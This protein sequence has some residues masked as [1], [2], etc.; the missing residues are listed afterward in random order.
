[1]AILVTGGAGYIGSHMVYELADAAERVVVLDNL[2]TGFDWAVAKGVPVIVGDTGDQTLV[3]QIIREHNIDSIV[4]FAACLVVPDSV[5]DPLGY[6]KNNTVLPG[7]D[8][9]CQQ[10]W[11]PSVHFFDGNPAQVPVTEDTLTAPHCLPESE[12]AGHWILRSPA[13]AISVFCAGAGSQHSFRC[14]RSRSRGRLS[15]AASK[16]YRW[17]GMLFGGH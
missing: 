7:A 14:I 13:L 17:S 6:Y 9:N 5:S 16:S 1:M 11:C 2:S 10:S 4:Y 3:A 15:C 8:R 12:I